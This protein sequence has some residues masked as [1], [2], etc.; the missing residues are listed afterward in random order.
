MIATLEYS[1]LL[2][3]DVAGR[4]EAT[5]KPVASDHYGLNLNLIIV[6]CRFFRRR[7]HILRSILIAN[8]ASFSNEVFVGSVE[9]ETY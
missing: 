1:R 4:I 7:A 9:I 6:P 5:S 3:K 8:K 2:T